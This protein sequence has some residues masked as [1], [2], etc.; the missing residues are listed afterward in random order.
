MCPLLLRKKFKHKVTYDT[1]VTILGSGGQSVMC[2]MMQLWVKLWPGLT[3]MPKTHEMYQWVGLA[4]EKAHTDIQ[5]IIRKIRRVPRRHIQSMTIADTEDS[6][7]DE[8]NNRLWKRHRGQNWMDHLWEQTRRAQL[9][10]SLH[11][12]PTM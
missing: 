9:E 2:F 11:N 3:R 4:A 1:L 6:E 10:S 8:E 7:D 12:F 5:Y